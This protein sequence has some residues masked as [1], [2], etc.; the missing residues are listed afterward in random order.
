MDLDYSTQEAK[1]INLAAVKKKE[2][3][4]LKRSVASFFLQEMSTLDK[5]NLGGKEYL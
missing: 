3:A 1:Y 4:L 2:E 5:L